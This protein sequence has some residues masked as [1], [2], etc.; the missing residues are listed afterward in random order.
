MYTL[1]VKPAGIFRK[2]GAACV[3]YLGIHFHKVNPLNAVVSCELLYNSPVTCTDYQ[4][5]S[6]IRVHGHGNVGNH[7]I[8]YK[9]ISFC[10]HDISVQGKYTAKLRRVKNINL[11]I[12]AFF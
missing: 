7:F 8:V 3:D 5:I 11:L 2:I 9:F 1:V 6:D 12:V 10:Q 4:N